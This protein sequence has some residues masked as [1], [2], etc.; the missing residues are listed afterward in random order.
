MVNSKTSLQLRE[1]RFEWLDRR[2]RIASAAMRSV[3]DFI[4][5]GA[6]KSGTTS[7]F[8]YLQQHPHVIPSIIKQVRYF[9][10][11]RDPARD[12][13]TRGLNWY[14]SHFP[15]RTTLKRSRSITGEASP[16]TMFHPLAAH[17]IKEAIP[18]VKLI[19]SLR[20]PVERAISHYGHALRFGEETLSLEEALAA[21]A[22]RLASASAYSFVRHSYV[23]RGMYARQLRTYLDLFPR[24]QLLI[25]PFEDVESDPRAAMRGIYCFLS[26]ADHSSELDIK[27]RNR[28]NK[29][30]DVAPETRA[31]LRDLFRQP[32]SELFDLIGERFN[33]D[34]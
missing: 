21:E 24:E 18:D 17:R 25:V 30:I 3:P 14:R 13:F 28:G 2:W 34:I 19:F 33:W 22:E 4:V 32:N 16:M 12:N 20:D 7:L 9:D 10:G 15:L 26:I 8:Y 29:H 27:V 11:G 1:G 5:A 6:M 23:A 31:R